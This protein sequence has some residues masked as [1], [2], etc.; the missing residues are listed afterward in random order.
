MTPARRRKSP[1]AQRQR[2]K[3]ETDS[4]LRCYP[5][6]KNTVP[7]S[8]SPPSPPTRRLR[9]PATGS[10]AGPRA[11]PPRAGPPQRRS[12]PWAGRPHV[13][14]PPDH[15]LNERGIVVAGPAA[16]QAP[17]DVEQGKHADQCRGGPGHG[18]TGSSARSWGNGP[19]P[20]CFGHRARPKSCCRLPSSSRARKQIVLVRG[21]RSGMGRDH[22]VRDC[23]E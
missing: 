17:V 7:R 12:K 21:G 1:V 4:L 9:R 5:K 19:M 23:P 14:G 18:R 3:R 15:A 16:A 8:R 2:G 22:T 20:P 11:P 6:S 10:R 13:L